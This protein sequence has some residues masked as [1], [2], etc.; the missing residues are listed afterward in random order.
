VSRYLSNPIFYLLKY[1]YNFFKDLDRL[2]TANYIPSNQDILRARLRTT[3]IFETAFDIGS[4]TYRMID[5]SGQRSERRK[6]IKTFDGVNAVLFVAAINGYDHALVEDRD[7]VGHIHVSVKCSTDTLQNQMDE[8][9]MLFKQISNS[10]YFKQ[11][12]MIL[13]LNKIDL[14]QEKLQSGM[15]PIKRYYADYEGD[16][17]DTQAG[18]EYFANKFK[19]LYRGAEEKLYIHFT[20]AI[21]TKLL[22][23]TMKSVQNTILQH[24]FNTIIL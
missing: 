1:P 14:L 16:P 4:H 20:N 6:W 19:S 23:V 18:Q 2:F 5:M 8:A 9:L 24:N 21:D 22:R 15:S 12:T 17:R 7:G 3:G 11:A 10:P 13:F